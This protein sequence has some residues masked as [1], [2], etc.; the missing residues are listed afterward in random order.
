[1]KALKRKTA[2][3]KSAPKRGRRSTSAAAERLELARR[4]PS[5][6]ISLSVLYAELARAQMDGDADAVRY[7]R[8]A[9]REATAPL[10]SGDIDE[11]LL[12]RRRARSA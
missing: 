8:D 5:T 9:I 6:A 1:M 7:A 11:P 12:P 4:D 2:T 3:R 10:P